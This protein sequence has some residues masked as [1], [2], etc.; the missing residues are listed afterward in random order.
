MGLRYHSRP[1][2]PRRQRRPVQYQARAS[3]AVEEGGANRDG[4]TAACA[5]AAHGAATKRVIGLPAT[6]GLALQRRQHP[7]AGER[8]ADRRPSPGWRRG[9]RQ[10]RAW[11]HRVAVHGGS[12]R[13]CRRR[14]RRRRGGCLW[15]GHQQHSRR[16]GKR[17][18][19][20]RVKHR[21]RRR[22]HRPHPTRTR[23]GARRGAGVNVHRGA[24]RE[25]PHAARW[26]QAARHDRLHHPIA[27]GVVVEWHRRHG[28][29]A[30][31]AAAAPVVPAPVGRGAR[32][33][34]R[35]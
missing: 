33:R 29:G 9:G 13:L 24:R 30:G 35:R 34:R 23:K 6:V 15:R 12:L 32:R 1:K 31:G 5:A 2:G 22:P 16:V 10:R 28:R 19:Q 4:C 11:R 3:A 8:R 26:A 14:H 27:G 17:H 7:R 21:G 18:D 20:Q 25:Q